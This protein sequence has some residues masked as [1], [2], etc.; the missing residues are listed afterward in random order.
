MA[1]R[2]ALL[3]SSH[4]FPVFP[5]FPFSLSSPSPSPDPRCPFADLP[6]PRCP[7]AAA[8]HACCVPR[9]CTINNSDDNIAIKS[10]YNEGGRTFGRPSANILVEDCIFGYG[11]GVA[12]G[13]ETSGGVFNVTVRNS[14]FTGLSLRTLRVKTARG[15]CVSQNA[16]VPVGRRPGGSALTNARDPVRARAGHRRGNVV[17]NITFTDIQLIGLH[18]IALTVD[19]LFESGGTDWT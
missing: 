5:F 9:N 13:S 1:V 7:F 15:R 6:D 11:D 12:I 18:G 16:A 3:R 2:L 17:S 19:M 14:V 8:R 4:S 10:G